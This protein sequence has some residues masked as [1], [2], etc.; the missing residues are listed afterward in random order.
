VDLGYDGIQ[1]DYP[2]FDALVPFKR[3]SPGRGKR[4]VKAVELTCEEKAFN[5]WLSVERV[6]VEHMFSRLKKFR[7]MAYMFRNRLKSYDV[8]M[9]VVCGLVNLRIAGTTAL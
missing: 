2:L 3:R 5:R 6:V 8:M 1:G 4:G 7:I 9:D